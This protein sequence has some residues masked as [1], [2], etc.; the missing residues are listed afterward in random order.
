M[1]YHGEKDAGWVERRKL[2]RGKRAIV[3]Q[4]EYQEKKS[5]TISG[6]RLLM[7]LSIR[8][9]ALA[10]RTKLEKYHPTDPSDSI[11]EVGSGAHGLIFGFE[12]N[13]AVGIDPLAVEYRS[14][15]PVWQTQTKTVAAVGEELP[16]AD[17]SFDVV[18]SDNVID[19][20]ADPIGIIY[21]LYRVLSPKGILYFT[22]NTHHPIYQAVS[23]LHS[24]WNAI[25]I[26]YEI[27]P[28]ADH[29]IH[30]TKAKVDDVFDSLDLN[31]LSRDLPF[32][33]A[34]KPKG[35]LGIEGRIKKV[36]PKN[37]LYELIAV[38]N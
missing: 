14:L 4:L 17:G 25:G 11:L 7:E 19:H 3:R 13:M 10:A 30:F 16:F 33:D 6:D 2:E 22:V 8:R 28:F 21:E 12:E 34:G 1:T 20:A 23:T 24:F 36:F 15:F 29:T 32:T 37:V 38:K 27:T 35:T 5:K 9:K 31:I 26:R 18:M